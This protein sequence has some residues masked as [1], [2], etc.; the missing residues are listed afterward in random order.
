MSPTNVWAVGF[1]YST[2]GTALI[3]H[4]DGTSWTR[5]AAPTEP[6]TTFVLS[7]VGFIT[8]NDGYAFGE[9]GS[10]LQTPQHSGVESVGADQPDWDGYVT[11]HWDGTSWTQ[12]QTD[13]DVFEALSSSSPTDAWMVGRSPDGTSIT[14]H[15]DGSDWTVVA[16]PSRGTD[17]DLLS[18]TDISPNDVWA[19][20]NAYER[21]TYSLHWNGTTW[22]LISDA[23]QRPADLMSIDGNS[24]HDVWISG[25]QGATYGLL[26]HWGGRSWTS[27][28]TGTTGLTQPQIQAV[29]TIAPDDAWAV[30]E[31]FLFKDHRSYTR[32]LILHWD[33][34]AWTRFGGPATTGPSPR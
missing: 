18:V 2:Y 26:E 8:P 34:T 15:W 20:G 1:D 5:V 17:N 4:W 11:L 13:G 29:A 25:D 23:A 31:Y 22:K 27:T 21:G 3:E 33:G 9:I 28:D 30:G 19:A 12:V 24:S 32:R 6:D 10:E 14:Q 16:S 7:G